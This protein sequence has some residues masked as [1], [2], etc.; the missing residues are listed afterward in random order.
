MKK[1]NLLS[2]FSFVLIG[3]LATSCQKS[4]PELAINTKPTVTVNS[5]EEVTSALPDASLKNQCQLTFATDLGGYPNWFHYN[6]KG[7]ADEWRVDFSG[8]DPV[9]YKMLMQY[10]NKNRLS[11]AQVHFNG[12]LI[13]TVK[14]DWRNNQISTEHWDFDGYLFDVNNTY[15]AKGQIVKREN[16]DGTS[17][18]EYKYSPEGNHL[19]DIVYFENEV[20]QSDEYT[21]N[22]PNKNP[23][24]A[25]QGLPYQFLYTNP[26]QAKWFPTSDKFLIYDN[27]NPIVVLNI[28]PSKT[29]MQLTHQNY[30]S[31][32][33]YYDSQSKSYL[34]KNFD[35][36]NCGPLKNGSTKA[37][38]LSAGK[39][40]IKRSPLLLGK[41]ENI[42]KQIAALRKQYLNKD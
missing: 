13:G 8:V 22:Q 11:D 24:L 40:L 36:Q 28:D 9:V 42:K 10:D 17:R 37:I 39:N 6:D 30:L 25:I 35:Y 34:T 12:V 41:P 26:F 16:S 27:G 1:N 21:Y 4:I 7:L 19:K 3:L 33:T 15:D 14:F 31:F 5:F 38:G 32:A 20:N 2:A 29:I 18:T 23:F